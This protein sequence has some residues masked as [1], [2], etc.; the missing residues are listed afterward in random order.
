MSLTIITFTC[1]ILYSFLR[2]Y[3]GIK[4]YSKL[5]MAGV[6]ATINE[7]IKNVGLEVEST[8]NDSSA[9]FLDVRELNVNNPEFLRY[10]I[11]VVA[12]NTDI[13]AFFLGL[14]S[15]DVIQVNSIPLSAQTHYMM[16]PDQPLPKTSQFVLKEINVSR[17]PPYELWTYFDKDYHVLG[18]ERLPYITINLFLRPWYIGALNNPGIYWSNIY[19]LTGTYEPGISGSIAIYKENGQL[20]GVLGADVSFISFTNFLNSQKFSRKGEAFIIDEQGKILIPYTFQETPQSIRNSNLVATGFAKYQKAHTKNFMF[21]YQG[22]NYLAYVSSLPAN[23]GKNWSVFIAAP[24]LDF[25]FNLIRIQFEIALITLAILLLSV[26]VISYFSK[27]ISKPI[28]TLAKEIDKITNLDLSSFKRVPSH[29]IEINMMDSSVASMRS[30]LRSFSRYVPKEIVK[31]LMHKHKDITLKVEKKALTIFFSDIQDFTG[32]AE[33]APLDE[34]MPVLS[35]YFDGLS[36]IILENKGT[37]DKYIGDSVM[38]FWG[39]PLENPRHA[40]DACR[41]ALLCHA[42]V[43]KFNQ[44]HRRNDQPL[45][46]TRFGLSS[47]TVLVG[48]IG[49][50]ERM[51]YT[52]I[53]DPVNL[54]SRLETTDKIYHVNII[55]GDSVYQQ[56]DNQ[57]LC[58]PLDKIRVKGKYQETDIYELIALIEPGTDISAT[59]EEIKLCTEFT[60]AYQTFMAGDV[61]QAQLLFQQL[62]QAFPEDYPTQIFLNRIADIA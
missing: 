11:Q 22:R 25:F 52:V 19:T 56:L 47:G 39:A 54:A 35:E 53:G 18:T 6:S 46:L 55:I 48:N 44:I 8:L 23:F 34:L 30:A 2:S 33:S 37:I 4:E 15:G 42:F 27:R 51:N 26:I 14:P 16:H 7:R 45:F 29:I 60:L 3:A 36:K 5:T 50:K 17:P 1:V 57:F 10:M 40:F 58:R 43:K 62:Y 49:T 9:M 28:V 38:A 41:T 61:K 13:S 59:P 32:F 20:A 21:Q 24:F 12:F 31:Q